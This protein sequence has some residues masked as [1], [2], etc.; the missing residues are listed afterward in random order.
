M[1]FKPWVR[2]WGSAVTVIGPPEFRDEIIAEL[3]EAARN[4]GLG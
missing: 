4:Y 2:Q 1:E 3:Q